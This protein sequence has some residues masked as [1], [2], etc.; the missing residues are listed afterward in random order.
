[1]VNG[2]WQYL[3]DTT[4]TTV[5]ADSGT[6]YRLKVATTVSNLTNA[7]CSV[8]NSQKI[9]VKV[10][11]TQCMLLDTRLLS[12]QGNILNNSG[13]LK[14]ASGQ[15]SNL[16]SYEVQRSVDGIYFSPAGRIAPANSDNGAIYTFVDPKAIS[17]V[18]YYRLKLISVQ[19]FDNR[20]SKTIVLF[21]RNSQL[22]V[23]AENPFTSN[24]R[25]DIFLPGDGNTVVKLYDLSGRI[26]FTK[27]LQL[28]KG[29]SK[30]DIDGL[31]ALP[32]G[33]YIL[34]TSFN[35]SIVQNKLFKAQ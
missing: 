7:S 33:V 1:M 16:K 4:F 34:Q 31:E 25:L 6:L 24:L 27:T 3:V 5:L 22:Q 21:N 18:A 9:Y 30:M 35:K 11:N 12:F 23:S 26:I 15:E 10:F 14:W 8:G 20:F 28:I 32:A 17:S 13:T 19:G 29:K 2:L